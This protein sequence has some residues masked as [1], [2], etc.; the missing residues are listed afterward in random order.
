MTPRE[1]R[2]KTIGKAYDRDN[3]PAGNKYQCWDYFAQF[4]YEMQI[5]VSTHCSLTGYVSDL[6]RLKDSYNYN[7][8]FE[9]ITNPADLQEGDWCLWDRGSSHN[10]SHV[11]LLVMDP[12]SG[13]RLEV[14]QNQGYPYVTEKETT[15]DIMG[16]LRW[17]GWK[18]TADAIPYGA[19]VLT[20]GSNSYSLYRQNP[21]TEY[22]AVLSAGL[23]KVQRISKLDAEVNVMAKITGANFFQMKDGQADPVN[24]TYG[25]IS[26]P[27]ND[28]WRQL[29][30]QNSTLYF[31][32]ETGVY[33][34]CTGINIEPTHNVYSPGSVFPHQGNY[35]YGTFIGIDCVNIVS[36]YTFCIRLKDG[37]YVLGLANQD[38]TPKQIANDFRNEIAFDSI[39]FLDGG[40]SAQFGRW[41]ASKGKFEYVRD[42][43]RACPSAVAII[44][45]KP[46][47][48][49]PAP[50]DNSD[51]PSEPPTILPNEPTTDENEKDEEIPMDNENKQESPVTEPIENWE[52]PEKQTNVIVE[53]IAALLSVKS[54]ITIA[55]TVAFIML[56]VEGKELPDKF[57]SIYTM[58]ISFFF[59]Y[60]FKK[61]EGGSDK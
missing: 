8:Y 25:D 40:G 13:K 38:G 9:Y 53:R 11:A 32:I 20:I 51:Q 3:Y 6:W 16:A 29:P 56:V 23:N 27:L 45:R 52:D 37:S 44:S 17:K 34:D 33:G 43:G 21:A 35:Q 39:A 42:T 4:V 31:D 28:V 7:K 26:S 50:G 36:R 1:W 48:P 30:N 47:A 15:W 54:I 46:I 59:G 49:V 14:G 22:P 19:S 61:A 55:L 41:D 24:T 60:Q 18:D 2:N 12:A 10:Y 5:P 58:C 57:V